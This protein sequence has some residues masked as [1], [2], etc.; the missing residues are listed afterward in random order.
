VPSGCFPAAKAGF[1]RVAFGVVP[2]QIK[3]DSDEDETMGRETAD[4]TGFAD[5]TSEVRG[6]WTSR[7]CCVSRERFRRLSGYVQAMPREVVGIGV[8]I[9]G[10]VR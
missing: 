5:C 9:P 8:V 6:H 2:A 7:S 4:A 3:G 10:G 1:A